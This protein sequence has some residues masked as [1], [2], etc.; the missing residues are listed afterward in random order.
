M[1]GIHPL[2]K[3]FAAYDVPVGALCND[4]ARRIQAHGAAQ[5]RA[6]TLRTMGVV[7]R[8]LH[9]CNGAVENAVEAPERGPYIRFSDIDKFFRDLELY[10]NLDNSCT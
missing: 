6:P 8:S 3:R 2:G 7:M 10:W 5:L 1:R 4:A 9:L